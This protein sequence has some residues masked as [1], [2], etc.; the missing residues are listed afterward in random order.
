MKRV[1]KKMINLY[2]NFI[3]NTD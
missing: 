1:F 3:T 2:Y